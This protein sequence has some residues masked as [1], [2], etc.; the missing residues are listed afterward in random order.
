MYVQ[1]FLSKIDRKIDLSD[2]VDTYKNMHMAIATRIIA[3]IFKIRV[4]FIFIFC[5]SLQLHPKVEMLK[6]VQ[7]IKMDLSFQ[8]VLG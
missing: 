4:L 5:S 1:V 2:K 6:M 8:T 3:I 7:K